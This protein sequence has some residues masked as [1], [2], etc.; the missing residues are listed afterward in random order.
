VLPQP[1]LEAANAQ[2]VLAGPDADPDPSVVAAWLASPDAAPL[3]PVRHYL[4]YLKWMYETF[5]AVAELFPRANADRAGSGRLDAQTMATSPEEMLHLANHLYVLASHGVAGA[6]LECGCFKGFSTCCLSHACDAL[7]RPLFVADSF[8]GLPPPGPDERAYAAG[9]FRGSRAEVEANVRAFGRPERVAYR[10]GWFADSLAGWN[11]PLALL[12]IDVDL[13]Q[14]ARDALAGA[15]PA[16][17]S[18]GAIFTHELLAEHVRD[19]EIALRGEPPGA[20][21]D[22]LAERGLAYRAAHAAGWTGVVTLADSPARGA[23]RLLAAL[24]D[25]LRDSDHRA[26]AARDALGLKN[27]LR[28]LGR[29]VRSAIVRA[30]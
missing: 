18:R 22:V 16:L 23:E 14:S 24:L 25:R 21:R 30:R 20:L 3:A 13:Y 5:H 11:E 12:W 2:G 9:D 19:G 26:R 4:F 7:A 8:A 29:R 10:P 15:L 28:D 1:V 17:D 27:A 6:V